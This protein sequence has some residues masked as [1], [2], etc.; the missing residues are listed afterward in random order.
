MKPKITII[1]INISGT[2]VDATIIALIL[3]LLL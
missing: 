2:V 1:I 3:R